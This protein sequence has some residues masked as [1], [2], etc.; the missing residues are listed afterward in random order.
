MSLV[1]LAEELGAAVSAGLLDRD[2]AVHQLAQY[3]DGGLTL[4][5]AAGLIDGWQGVRARY[6]DLF[7]RTEMGLAACEA[8]KRSRG[9]AAA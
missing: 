8:A 9:G 6:A 4:Y 7:M 1:P 2:V 5:G 3:S